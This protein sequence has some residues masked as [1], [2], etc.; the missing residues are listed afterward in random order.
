MVRILFSIWGMYL[1]KR[2]GGHLLNNLPGRDGY[3]AL[4]LFPFSPWTWASCF[5]CIYI[6]VCVYMVWKGP[7]DLGRLNPISSTGGGDQSKV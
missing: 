7:T 6:Y 2:R 5:G 1:D 4:F 3:L